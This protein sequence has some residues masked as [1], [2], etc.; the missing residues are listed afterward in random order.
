MS[1]RNLAGITSLA[2][3]DPAAQPAP[4]GAKG[5]DGS[6]VTIDCADRQPETRNHEPRCAG[7]PSSVIHELRTPLTSIHGYAQVLQRSLRDDPRASKS[8]GVM[9]RETTRLTAM[10]GNLSELAELQ[11]GEPFTPAVRVDVAQLVGDVVDEIARRDGGAH[12]ILLAVDGQAHCNATLL[13]QA[14]L[15]VIGN[16]TL[17]S[18]QNEPIS[19]GVERRGDAI[20]ITVSDRGIGIVPADDDRIYEPF[21]RGLNARQFGSRG[22][23]LGLF[24]A[25]QA[26]GR[27]GGRIE[28]ERHD[29]GGTIFRLSVPAAR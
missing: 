22:L 6:G 8:L 5:A 17:Y 21:E 25:R 26:L 20:Q 7:L 10:L 28:H 23:G 9:V 13:A 2:R 15:H 4:H 19:I 24:L 14:M 12:P 3:T 29:D 18:P 1:G 27:T 11:S 16:A